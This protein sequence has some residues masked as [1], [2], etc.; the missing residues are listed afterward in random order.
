MTDFPNVAS[1][2]R[3]QHIA[4]AKFVRHARDESIGVVFFKHIAAKPGRSGSQIRGRHFARSSDRLAG[5]KDLGQG[6]L[7]RIVKTLGQF[8][9]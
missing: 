9:Q 5:P 2:H 3:D 6:N 7:V 8:V 4:G 1:S